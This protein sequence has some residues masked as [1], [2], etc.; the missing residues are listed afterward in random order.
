MAHEP[1]RSIILGIH[2]GLRIRSEALTLRWKRK[3]PRQGDSGKGELLT[4]DVG[5]IL[6]QSLTR[7]EGF[8]DNLL[9]LT[10]CEKLIRGQVPE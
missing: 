7:A 3:L 8:F 5:P 2:C 9:S 4:V 10:L 1:L 6:R